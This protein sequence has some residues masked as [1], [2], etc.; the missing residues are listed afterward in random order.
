ML[1]VGAAKQS[2]A[3]R[4][5]QMR[6]RE[7][8]DV[9]ELQLAR[10]RTSA[11]AIIGEAAATAVALVH[12]PLD[13]IGDV[14]GR[15][16]MHR[17]DRWLAR[18]PTDRE[19]LLLHLLDQQVERPFEDAGEVSVRNTVSEQVLCLAQLVAKCAACG[20]AR[21]TWNS[22]AARSRTRCRRSGLRI[23]R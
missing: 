6:A 23:G 10:L 13:R 15:R 5:V 9:I 11:A 20:I 18:F 21:A 8:V 16:F 7:S 1:V 14:A 12:R 19:P 17:F 22:I 2:D 4:I 3:V